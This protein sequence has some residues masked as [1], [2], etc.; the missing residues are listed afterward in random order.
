MEYLPQKDSEKY[1]RD[2][3]FAIYPTVAFNVYSEVLLNRV[4]YCSER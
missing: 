3:L 1:L 2:K 4:R